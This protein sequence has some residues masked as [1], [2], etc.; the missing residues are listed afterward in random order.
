MD[1][2]D[3][4][5][6]TPKPDAARAPAARPPFKLDRRVLAGAIVVLA[7]LLVIGVLVYLNARSGRDLANGAPD[8]QAQVDEEWPGLGDQN[9]LHVRPLTMPRPRPTPGMLA[10]ILSGYADAEFTIGADGKAGN[11]RIVRESAPDIGYGAEARRMIAAATWPTDWRGRSAPFDASYRVIFPPGRGPSEIEPL[12]IASPNLTPEI[13]AL[14]RDVAVTLLV[15]VTPEGLVDSARVIDQDVESSAAAAEAMRVALGARYP[16]NG[17]G[18]ETQLVVRFNVTAAQT[19]EGE[20]PRGPSVSY[21]DVP[22]S[23]R[24]SASD[25]SRYYPRRARYNNIDGRVTL[26]CIVQRNLRLDC[27]VAEENPPGQGFGEAA[28]RI[29]RRFRAQSQFPDGRSTVGAQVSMP[30][31]FRA[32]E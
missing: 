27:S 1:V 3:T 16:A 14:R 25:Y 29:A 18:Y 22:F 20:L 26:A 23:Q 2:S 15:H 11:I 21:A 9:R 7:A 30:M 19:A 32:A 5:P 13:M 31:A 17:A 28:L 6:E 8:E 24:P 12:A 4:P 10:S